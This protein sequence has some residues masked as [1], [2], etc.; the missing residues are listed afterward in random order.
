MRPGPQEGVAHLIV[1]K[2]ALRRAPLFLQAIY[3]EAERRGWEV[4]AST[5]YSSDGVA[6]VVRGHKYE[7]SIYELHDRV[8][9]TSEEIE[10]WRKKKEWQLRW[11]PRLKQP[12]LKSVPNGYLKLESER[13]RGGGRS[14]WSEGLRGPLDRKLPAFFDELERRAVEDDERAER[15]RQEELARR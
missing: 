1:S 12:T 10:R 9:M 4:A 7:V 11:N 15:R 6:I 3:L 5:G 14:S 2:R 13:Y 8:A